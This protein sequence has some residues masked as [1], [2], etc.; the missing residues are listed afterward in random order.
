[1]FDTDRTGGRPAGLKVKRRGFEADS[2]YSW[3][4]M[5][6]E[7]GRSSCCVGFFYIN[8]SNFDSSPER[9]AILLSDCFRYCRCP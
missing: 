4:I 5:T 3:N 7:R 9:M 2:V 6:Q 8:F 1:M